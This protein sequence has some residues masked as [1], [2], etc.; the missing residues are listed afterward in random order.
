MAI[1]CVLGYFD[2]AGMELVSDFK[3]ESRGKSQQSAV[4][5]MAVIDIFRLI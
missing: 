4:S 3:E 2:L 5:V 1:F